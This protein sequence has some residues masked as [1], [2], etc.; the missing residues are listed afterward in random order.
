[1]PIGKE[2]ARRDLQILRQLDRTRH[3]FCRFAVSGAKGS[4]QVTDVNFWNFAVS[5]MRKCADFLASAGKSGNDMGER[6]RFLN[7]C[8]MRT[9]SNCQVH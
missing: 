5:Q 1:M 3:L 8:S 2:S 6:A 9:G 4:L 7:N